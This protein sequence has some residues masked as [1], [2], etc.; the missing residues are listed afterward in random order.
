MESIQ[1]YDQQSRKYT[2]LKDKDGIPSQ[3]LS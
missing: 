1:E 2:S 3:P